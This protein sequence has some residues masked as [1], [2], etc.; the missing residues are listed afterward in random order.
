MERNPST[1]KADS[2]ESARTQPREFEASHRMVVIVIAVFVLGLIGTALAAILIPFG[3]A[4]ELNS[5][6]ETHTRI[7]D[8]VRENERW[9]T[10]W[11]ELG[12]SAADPETAPILDMVTVNWDIS[13]DEVGGMMQERGIGALLNDELTEYEDWEGLELVQYA[14]AMERYESEEHAANRQFM[15]DL[16]VMMVA[17]NLINRASE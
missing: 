11:D 14:G 7:I 8:H 4:D 2:N 10:S 5:I 13:L 3:V 15:R 6:R 17:R 16:A 9:P 12:I 1:S